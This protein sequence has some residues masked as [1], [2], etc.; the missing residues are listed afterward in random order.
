MYILHTRIYGRPCTY[1]VDN[2]I[3]RVVNSATRSISIYIGTSILFGKKKNYNNNNEN[4]V[5]PKWY[6]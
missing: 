4:I 5:K 6:Q 3:I 2:N 1:K